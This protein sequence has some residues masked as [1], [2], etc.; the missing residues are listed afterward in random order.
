MYCCC[1]TSPYSA[2]SPEN[3]VLRSHPVHLHSR[4]Q[5]MSAT[6]LWWALIRACSRWMLC[7]AQSKDLSPVRFADSGRWLFF[8]F[9]WLLLLL[10]AGLEWVR[11]VSLASLV[12]KFKILVSFSIVWQSVIKCLINKQVQLP[13]KGKMLISAFYDIIVTNYYL[14]K[15]LFIT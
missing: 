10:L 4:L 9:K 6:S 11:L 3:Q 1:G 8:F 7:I 14:F 13:L 5:L 15:L 2:A 12:T